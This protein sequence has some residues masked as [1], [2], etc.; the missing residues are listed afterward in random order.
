M[1]GARVVL[2]VLVA[3]AAALV[4][5][6]GVAA[7]PGLPTVDPDIPAASAPVASLTVFDDERWSFEEGA[8]SHPFDVPTSS[9]N[10]VVLELSSRPD[11][12]P[13][14]RLFGVAIDGAEVLRGTTPRA[15]F[16]IKKDVTV[17]SGNWPATTV[18]DI[19]TG[20]WVARAALHR[21]AQVLR[22]SDHD[23]RRPCG[24]AGRRP[25]Q[26]VLP[27]RSGVE[28]RARW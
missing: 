6:G 15:A 14:D 22:R 8:R 9:W 27:P 28:P 12:D 7:L 16:T 24:R 25:G 19:H 3:A 23:A 18:M 17:Y 13:W 5:I 1:R 11:G 26:V 2:G 10:R 21:R 20:T 4:P